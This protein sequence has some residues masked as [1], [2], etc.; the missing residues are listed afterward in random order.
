[1]LIDD[2]DVMRKKPFKFYYF[3]YV[4]MEINPM[5]RGEQLFVAL[6]IIIS[7]CM[8]ALIIYIAVKVHKMKN[9]PVKVPPPP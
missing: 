4:K 7:L 5:S 8:L 2:N 9:E 1:M 6:L 3:R